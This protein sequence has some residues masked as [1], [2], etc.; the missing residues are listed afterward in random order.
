MAKTVKE[1]EQETLKVAH[2]AKRFFS[3]PDG[4]KVLEYLE[5]G[6]TSDKLIG[7]D[8][9]D[10]GFRVGQFEC[11]RDIQKLIRIGELDNE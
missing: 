10:T 7:N 4:K 6:W 9:Q 8:P 1:L 5:D 11:F 3:T 2:A